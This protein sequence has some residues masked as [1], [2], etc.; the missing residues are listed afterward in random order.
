MEQQYYVCILATDR[1]GTLYIGVTNDIDRRVAEHKQGVQEGF[2]SEYG[3]NRLVHVETFTDIHEA[4]L[5]DKRLKKWNR[6]WKL[7]LIEKTNP[8]WRD[9]SD[10]GNAERFSEYPAT[11]GPVFPPS[12]E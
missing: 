12:R 8:E 9:L 11:F 7:N 4:I 10:T 6:Q 3:V 2:T 5:R 1:N